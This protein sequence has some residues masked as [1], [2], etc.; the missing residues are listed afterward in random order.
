MALRI[1]S[2]SHPIFCAVLDESAFGRN[3]AQAAER[4]FEAGID[5]IQLRD[6][7]LGSEALY[8]LA[9]TLVDAARMVGESARRRDRDQ[10]D[11]GQPRVVINRR[12]DIALAAGADGVHL[13]FD[14]LNA[15]DARAL[16]GPDA[17]IGASFHSPAEVENAARE[18][19]D[20]L[21]SYAHLAPIWDPHSKPVTRSALGMHSLQK[22]V[23]FG[24]PVL[25]QGGVD[26]ARAVQAIDCG[27]LGIA[28]T[29][30]LRRMA[31]QIHMAR[32]IRHALDHIPRDRSPAGKELR[33]QNKP[34]GDSRAN[35]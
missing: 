20:P 15:A 18:A 26:S 14:A 13:G 10:A 24:I 7:N 11:R 22:A 16:L 27:A 1:F 32:Q 21:L 28:V 30:G 3:P 12:I 2:A 29:G 9:K 4:L 6:R 17:L 31:D 8:S 25:A 23:K 35:P 5:W 33:N 19:E 34:G